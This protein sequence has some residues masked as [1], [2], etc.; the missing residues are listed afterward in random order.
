MR[1][2]PLASLTLAGCWPYLPGSVDDYLDTDGVD[3]DTELAEDLVLFGLMESSL[4]VGGYWGEDTPSGTFVGG[5]VYAM[6]FRGYR[7][8]PLEI[9]GGGGSQGGCRSGDTDVPEFD[10]RIAVGGPSE[11]TL[12]STFQGSITLEG[13]DRFW[14]ASLEEHNPGEG[15]AYRLEPFDIDNGVVDVGR[16]LRTPD[17]PEVLSPGIYGTDI[18]SASRSNFTV[19][20]DPPDGA[21]G[22]AVVRVAP[23]DASGDVTDVISCVVPAGDTLWTLDSS[24]LSGWSSAGGAYL[25]VGWYEAE[26]G[27]LGDDVVV[28]NR[29]GALRWQQGFVGLQ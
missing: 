17:L 14:A 24:S 16:V 1:W 26:G 11:I 5:S 3:T 22:R 20:I 2:I 28:T 8:S 15:N 4:V 10:S 19:R 6:F 13:D 27:S 29:V 21:D 12:T 7:Y 18:P 23:V 25:L 9:Y